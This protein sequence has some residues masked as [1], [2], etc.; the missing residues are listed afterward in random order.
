ML[1][2]RS[3]ILTFVS[4]NGFPNHLCLYLRPIWRWDWYKKKRMASHLFWY[5]RF[6]LL[7]W[8]YSTTYKG[9]P[10]RR[11]YQCP[12]DLKYKLKKLIQHD[13]SK[14]KRKSTLHITC[15]MN[16]WTNLNITI[17]GKNDKI[18]T[19]I[20]RKTQIELFQFCIEVKKIT[21]R[22]K[23]CLSSRCTSVCRY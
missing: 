8:S 2:N 22:N 16:T 3:F 14:F 12:N 21:N 11:L 7:M 10:Y 13:F 23:S 15:L 1:K 20:N 18:G 9:H 6:Y 4:N 5:M 17:T 19:N